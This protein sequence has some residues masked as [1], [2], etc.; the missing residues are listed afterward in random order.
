MSDTPIY[1]E[2][3]DDTPIYKDTDS[4]HKPDVQTVIKTVDNTPNN[5]IPSPR[6]RTWLYGIVAA[7][8]PLLSVLGIVTPDVGGH[9]LT[10][11]AAVLGIGTL[12]LA[13]VNTPKDK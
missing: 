3:G 11:A 13:A 12:T 9:V 5:W 10:I 8:V 7:V 1:D 2:V 4:M 6:V